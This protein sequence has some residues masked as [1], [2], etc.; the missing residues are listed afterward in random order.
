[1]TIRHD[2][3]DITWLECRERSDGYHS[4]SQAARRGQGASPETR[5]APQAQPRSRGAFHPRAG[6][7]GG[8]EPDQAI[9]GFPDW[10]IR[11]TRPGIDLDPALEENRRPHAG[12]DL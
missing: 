12:I 4:C 8:R 5:D 7:A 11:M 9:E 1:L 2:F 6:G 3:I 10:F